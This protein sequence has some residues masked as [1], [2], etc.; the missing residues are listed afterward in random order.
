[1]FVFSFILLSL[2]ILPVLLQSPIVIIFLIAFSYLYCS[3]FLYQL[4]YEYKSSHLSD[5]SFSS[6]MSHLSSVYDLSYLS[7]SP[8]FLLIQLLQ[9]YG[10]YPNPK[11]ENRC[12][13][14]PSFSFLAY[15]AY[16][17]MHEQNND[18]RFSLH[19]VP[20]ITKCWV[21]ICR[22]SSCASVPF[23]YNLLRIH[24]YTF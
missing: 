10:T 8:P 17:T 13:C 2:R 22:S 19:D 15:L 16:L 11:V 9:L 20:S 4:S 21:P 18:N 12:A 7:Y 24:Q 3:S 1:M 14:P 23:N 5:L 6:D